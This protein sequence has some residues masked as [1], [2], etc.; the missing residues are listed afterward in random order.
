MTTLEQMSDLRARSAAVLAEMQKYSTQ[1]LHLSV[2]HVQDSV[3]KF[4]PGQHI[5]T[6][7]L[8]ATLDCYKTPKTNDDMLEAIKKQW[9]DLKVSEIVFDKGANKFL[10][11]TT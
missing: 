2:Q 11:F 10:I 6:R 8:V 9:P 1:M 5:V 3:A 4:A 7:T